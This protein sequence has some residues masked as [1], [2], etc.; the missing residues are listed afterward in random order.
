MRVILYSREGCHLCDL[1]RDVILAE[2]SGTVFAF[3]EVDIGGDDALELQYGIRIPVVFVDGIER[4][5]VVVDP[6]GFADAVAAGSG[7]AGSRRSSR[8]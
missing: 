4:F 6:A 5:E 7:P 1:A 2:R 3:D 8:S